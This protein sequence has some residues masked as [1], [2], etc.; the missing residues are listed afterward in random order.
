MTENN[1]LFQPFHP[2]IPFS[3]H[4]LCFI[5]S[6]T[7]FSFALWKI[8]LQRQGG[9]TEEQQLLGSLVDGTTGSLPVAVV[10]SPLSHAHPSLICGDSSFKQAASV[11]AAING[12]FFCVDRSHVRCFRPAGCDF[13]SSRVRGPKSGEVA[14]L[15][16][17]CETLV[18]VVSCPERHEIHHHNPYLY[19]SCKAQLCK[20]CLQ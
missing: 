8:T 16:F 15:S 12:F 20:Q 17:I 4:I 13:D 2:F 9:K 19:L 11:P 14:R 10:G 5:Y 1:L 6:S 7:S 18:E 3:P